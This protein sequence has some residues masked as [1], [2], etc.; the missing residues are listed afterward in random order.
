M[1]R[2]FYLP[3]LSLTNSG[4]ERGLIR[5]VERSPLKVESIDLL[6]LNE[7]MNSW[8]QLQTMSKLV[9]GGKGKIAFPGLS[10]EWLGIYAP[11]D[12]VEWLH[13]TKL[14]KCKEQV[15]EYLVAG[16]LITGEPLSDLLEAKAKVIMERDPDLPKMVGFFNNFDPSKELL[17]SKLFK[18]YR[19]DFDPPEF[20]HKWKPGGV[21]IQGKI[22]Y[23][24]ESGGY[25]REEFKIWKRAFLRKERI[26]GRRRRKISPREAPKLT[27]EVVSEIEGILPTAGTL[28][29]LRSGGT[30]KYKLL[31]LSRQQDIEKHLSQLQKGNPE[32]LKQVGN[33][34]SASKKI[35]STIRTI[36]D[37]TCHRADDWFVLKV[38][39]VKNLLSPVWRGAQG[40][41]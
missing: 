4:V 35:V 34:K 14:Q 7:E 25:N 21:I 33:F 9:R 30:R 15:Y 1:P 22:A 10:E 6:R 23:L 11:R 20:L 37:P 28:H 38:K 8:R 29:I 26:V 13:S 31:W 12:F 24:D 36:L 2:F 27:Q 16:S 41:F 19:K 5:S 18:K 3:N 32:T 40:V 39:D 17:T